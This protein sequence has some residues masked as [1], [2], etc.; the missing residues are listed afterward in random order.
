MG[1]MAQFGERLIDNGY[2]ITP[3]RAGTKRP[4]LEAW[5]TTVVDRERLRA[6]VANGSASAGV[7]V[8][9]GRVRAVDVDVLDERVADE[10]VAIAVRDL[11]ATLVRTGRA[12]KRLLVYRAAD[13]PIPKRATAFWR[14]DAG[15]E[16][17]VEVLGVGQQFVAFGVHPDTGRPYTW[18]DGHDLVDVALDDLPAVTV[19]QV[20]AFLRACEDVFDWHG[21][22]RAPNPSGERA[23]GAPDL[24]D[25]FV[26]LPKTG[27]TVDDVRA[28]LER[29]DAD[30]RDVWLRV[31]G[32]L[33]HQFGE[34]GRELWDD[35]S[36]TSHKF[37]PRDQDKTWR[38]FR[39]WRPG[40]PVATILSVFDLAGVKPPKT[41]SAAPAV[42]DDPA[43]S[44]PEPG[45]AFPGV[46]W[47]DVTVEG[48][49]AVELVEGLLGVNQ[50]SLVAAG[51]N[52]GKSL[53][54]IDFAVAVAS[55]ASWRGQ[56]QVAQG[57]V[58]YVAAES[59]GSI[60][61]RAL[62]IKAHARAQGRDV[63]DLPVFVVDAPID[64]R[65]D[66]GRKFAR[67]VG[68][69]FAAMR[70][71]LGAEPVLVVVD[72]L[73][74]AAPGIAEN[75]A[76]E[77]GALS[78]TVQRLSRTMGAAHW[79]I[80]HHLG[81]DADR[82]AR[83]H[84]S[85]PAAVDTEIRLSFDP[86]TRQVTG[87]VTKQRELPTRGLEFWFRIEGVPTGRITNFLRPETQPVLV[88]EFQAGTP[89]QSPDEI[90]FKARVLAAIARDPGTTTAVVGAMRGQSTQAGKRVVD[91]LIGE[92]LVERVR[93]GHLEL[94]PDGR[95]FLAAAN[96]QDGPENASDCPF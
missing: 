14:D 63:D 71:R 52:V 27:I 8:L 23:G 59:P 55:G 26:G 46:Y 50:A 91:G 79:M 58:L 87:T 69:T 92:G 21:F 41:L 82:G 3:I 66:G 19:D 96:A 38:G 45:D 34:E 57:P 22:T 68:A 67:R 30:D 39:S 35:W 78:A 42:L 18:A 29:I 2:S 36:Q 74:M 16:H 56:H 48:D 43:P 5:T 62:A 12:P 86:L 94:T 7:G 60:R 40:A 77:M 11:G 49:P 95:G 54:A 24:D 85:L 75:D 51:T 73:A 32:A 89:D 81:K 9:C 6:L 88:H 17:R 20:D 65:A 13:A 76:D 28:A 1:E 31:G 25:P 61:A 53:V 72:T 47:G 93:R 80:L 83:G 4:A 33:H 10:I 64:I 84:S 44:A 15:R 70:E 90:R 37:D